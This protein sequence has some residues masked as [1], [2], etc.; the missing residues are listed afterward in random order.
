MKKFLIISILAIST[1]YLLIVWIKQEPSSADH[2]SKI[3]SEKSHYKIDNENKKKV[4]ELH[5]KISAFNKKLFNDNAEKNKANDSSSDVDENFDVKTSLFEQLPF[6][7]KNIKQIENKLGSV[8][9]LEKKRELYNE[10]HDLQQ[11]YLNILSELREKK[12]INPELQKKINEYKKIKSKFESKGPLN[13]SDKEKL[14][15][16]KKRIFYNE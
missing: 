10:Y 6:I 12:D 3:S 14:A 9:D 13:E 8:S 16:I 11:E 15:D 5:S 1:F 2:G 7:G 4:K